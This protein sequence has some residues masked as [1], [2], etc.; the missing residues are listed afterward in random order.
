[1]SNVDSSPDLFEALAERVA[2]IVLSRLPEP[3]P[4]EPEGFVRVKKA[5]EYLDL[6]VAAVRMLVKRELL[7]CHRLGNRVLFD[8]AELREY[9][10]S[11]SAA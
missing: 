6:S 3:A 1:M 2:E 10:R 5:A 8:L 9:V 7:P 4:Q 11:G